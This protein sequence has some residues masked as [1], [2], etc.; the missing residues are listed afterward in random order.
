LLSIA[1]IRLIIGSSCWELQARNCKH[2]YFRNPLCCLSI[3]WF[4]CLMLKEK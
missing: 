3:T 4:W 2:W 1:L